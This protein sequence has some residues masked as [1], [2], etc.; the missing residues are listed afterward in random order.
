MN[1][2]APGMGKVFENLLS[3]DLISILALIFILFLV[4]YLQQ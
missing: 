4:N 2:G 1:G 3:K